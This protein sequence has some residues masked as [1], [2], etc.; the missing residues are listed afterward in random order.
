MA[1]LGGRILVTG[2][3]GFLGS[4]LVDRLLAE[5]QQVVGLDNL[6]MG[7]LDNVAHHLTNPAF[8]LIQADVAEP[9][10]FDDVNGRFDVVVHLAAF[11]IPRYGKA[12]DTLRINSRGIDHVLDFARRAAD[13]CVV[14]STSDVY[15]RNPAL[16]FSE[17]DDSVL[18]SSKVARWG[19]AVSKLFDE[20]LAFAYQD[21]F[22]LPVT[23]LR[24]F[25][26]Y[27]PRHHLSWWG[28]PQSVFIDAVLNNREVTIHGDG[29]QTRSFTYVADTVEG[30]YAATVKPEANGEIFNIGSTHEITILELAQVI[31]RLAD[32]P[33]PLRLKFVPYE[34][35]TGRAYEDVRR[36]VPD[37]SRAER[38]LGVKATIGL[39]EGLAATID[40][41]RTVTTEAEIPS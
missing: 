7:R 34:S 31:K 11:K 35:F 36:R 25:G 26:S 8:R 21:A 14:A 15:G 6:S 37:V 2:A 3:A 19:Y 16:P 41:Q 30:I 9:T 33:H 38:I 27:G 20:H 12:I 5:G 24:F 39:D 23:I 40:W 29:L 4:H 28:G 13:K 10:V 1:N 17:D 32:T 18:G 22:G